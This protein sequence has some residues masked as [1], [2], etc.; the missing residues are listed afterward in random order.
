MDGCLSNEKTYLIQLPISLFGVEF[1]TYISREDCE[2][3]I[4]S[5]EVS[6]NCISFYLWC[7]LFIF[8]CFYFFLIWFA[9]VERDWIW[10]MI[11][12]F[13]YF[14]KIIGTCTINYI[15]PKRNHNFYLLILLQYHGQAL[16]LQNF[17]LHIQL[18][19]LHHLY[20]WVLML[21]YAYC[22]FDC[23]LVFYCLGVYITNIPSLFISVG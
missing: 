4:S 14:D 17:S 6:S 3:I 19:H 18:M 13:W 21:F 12:F 1:Q 20:I 9:H 10:L 7:A 11:I 2:Y 23:N 8:I 16:V 22:K 15:L 5:S